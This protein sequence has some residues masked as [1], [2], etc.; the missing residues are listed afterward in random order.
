MKLYVPWQL[1]FAFAVMAFK[2]H[3]AVRYV[4]APG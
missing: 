1:A 3:Q 4:R 2:D